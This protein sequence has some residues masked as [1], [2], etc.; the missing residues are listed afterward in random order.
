MEQAPTG[1]VGQAHAELLKA[2]FVL[3]QCA[4][5]SDDIA[6]LSDH[7]EI[8]HSFGVECDKAP[9]DITFFSATEGLINDL[10][11]ANVPA[12]ALIWISSIDDYTINAYGL[13]DINFG[14]SQGS[15]DDFGPLR[16]LAYLLVR[17]S[18]C[19]VNNHLI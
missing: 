19:L 2:L 9:L 3:D 12:L 14:L 16:F 7:R 5:D 11:R 18:C 8:L 17:A 4:M 13:L 15:V 6:N 1:V 10:E